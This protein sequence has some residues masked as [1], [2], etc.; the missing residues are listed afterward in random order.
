[1]ISKIEKNRSIIIEGKG[2]GGGLSLEIC[3]NFV[4]TE[5][6]LTLGD[7]PR[8]EEL[9]LFGRAIFV[10]RISLFHLFRNSQHLQK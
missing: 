9:K 2:G 7:E 4:E 3:Q 8:W 10:T 1:M 6:F 5:V